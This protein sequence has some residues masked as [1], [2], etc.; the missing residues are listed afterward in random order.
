MRKVILLFALIVSVNL[1]AEEKVSDYSMSYFDG[2]VYDVET[3]DVSNG[4]FTYYIYCETKDRH[5][6]IGFS[7]KNNQISDFVSQLRLIKEK[8]IEWKKTAEDNNIKSFDKNFDVNFQSV[9][10]FWL[11]GSKWCFSRVKFKPYFKVTDSGTTHVV[12]SAGQMKASTNEYMTTKGFYIVF[13]STEEIDSFIEAIN[14]THAINK[15]QSDKTKQD[16]FK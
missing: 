4:E 11:Y 8:F 1:F 16:L 2:K 12:F 13:S 14:P 5:D 10:T 7:L 15:S 3:T 6:Q 9:G